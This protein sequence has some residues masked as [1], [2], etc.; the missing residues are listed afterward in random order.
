MFVREEQN[1]WRDRNYL[2]GITKYGTHVI[3]ASSVQDF[4]I[5]LESVL[6]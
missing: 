4:V 3:L 5:V 6:Q 2:A 1:R